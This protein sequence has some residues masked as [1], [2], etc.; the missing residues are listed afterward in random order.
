MCVLSNRTPNNTQC[1]YINNE[2]LENVRSFCYLGVVFTSNGSM[3][4]ALK[5]LSDQAL[6]AIHGL[7]T[8][9][10]RLNFNIKSKLML[11]DR[12][13]S[14]ILLYCSEDL[15]CFNTATIEGV[16]MKYRKKILGIKLQT[17]NFAVLGELGRFSF[18]T[19]FKERVL[20]Y[21]LKIISRPD[22]IMYKHF[23]S[24]DG[25]IES[26]KCNA[27]CKFVKNTLDELGYSN[28]WYDTNL[29]LSIFPLLQNR[30]RDQFRQEWHTS[31]TSMSK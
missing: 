23:Y 9:F 16:H 12:M 6:K 25:I 13:V 19:L 14:P 10:S 30:L 20:K 28:L 15:G 24:Q 21:W 2:P 7:Y 22:S 29:N 3:T 11:F 1:W 17:P 27:W 31:I 5:H 8:L 18:K 4:Q 26:Q